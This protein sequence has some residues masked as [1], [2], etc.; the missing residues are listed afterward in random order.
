M[1][2]I[3][4]QVSGGC[5]VVTVGIPR[6]AITVVK[7][8]EANASFCKSAGEEATVGEVAF[9][10]HLTGFGWFQGNIEGI[11]CCK[12]HAVGCF[13]RA[14]TGFECGVGISFVAV[15]LVELP[16]EFDLFCLICGREL[17]VFEEGNHLSR[18][19]VGVVDV[20]ALMFAWKKSVGPKL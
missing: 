3:L 4:A 1:I 16:H 18:V 14:D 17:C 8:R 13:H 7:L 11:R 10:I 2:D 5:G 15:F 6:L 19:E 12:L 9:A 20:G